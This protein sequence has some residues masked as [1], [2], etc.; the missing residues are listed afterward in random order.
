MRMVFINLLTVGILFVCIY[1][2]FARFNL[3]G[4]ELGFDSDHFY[5][6]YVR[7]QFILVSTV[8]VAVGVSSG[9]VLAIYS[10]FLSHRIAGP[11]ENLKIRF[12]SS[13]N[14]EVISKTAFR[15]DDFFHDLASAYNDHIEAS[16]QDHYENNE[17]NKQD[18]KE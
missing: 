8:F 17:S 12:R 13:K 7:E 4:E 1:I 18:K 6:R 2:V 10:F 9:M 15:K 14:G 5:Y 11:L 3:L 16:H